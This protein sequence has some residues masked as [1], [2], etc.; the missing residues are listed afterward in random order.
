MKNTRDTFESIYAP[1]MAIG[2]IKSNI[3][4]ATRQKKLENKRK[5]IAR[6]KRLLSLLLFGGKKNHRV[7][8]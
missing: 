5:T 8:V 4:F 6:S 2:N 3:L 7:F 1:R